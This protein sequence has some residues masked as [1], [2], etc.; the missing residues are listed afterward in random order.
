MALYM[1]NCIDCGKLFEGPEDMLVCRPCIEKILP[2]WDKVRVYLH[3]NNNVTI[4]KCME[5]TGV[6][7]RTIR[8]FLKQH[9][10]R[11]VE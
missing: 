11:V 5:G 6:S 3:K 7:D 1:K 10:L 4:K 9:K 8:L 2:E